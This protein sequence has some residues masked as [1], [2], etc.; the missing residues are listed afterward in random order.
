M[1]DYGYFGK[2]LTGYVHYMQAQK[3]SG[4]GG[5]GRRGKGGCGSGLTI[6]IVIGI[7]WMIAASCS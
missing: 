4:S 5:G 2:G 6:M 1:G 7:V 3:E